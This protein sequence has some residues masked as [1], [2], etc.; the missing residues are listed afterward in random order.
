MQPPETTFEPDFVPNAQ[1]VFWD[2]MAEFYDARDLIAVDSPGH[3]RLYAAMYRKPRAL[4]IARL[5]RMDADEMGPGTRDGQ[6]F[7]PTIG[8]LAGLVFKRYGIAPDMAVAQLYRDGD[9]MCA[10]HADSELV[11]GP[12]AG[13]ALVCIMSFGATRKLSMRPTGIEPDHE[14][15]SIDFDLT[16]GSLFTMDG[17]TQR[18]YLHSIP[19]APEGTGPRISLTF[20]FRQ[21]DKAKKLPWLLMRADGH[22]KRTHAVPLFSGRPPELAEAWERW[23]DEHGPFVAVSPKGREHRSLYRF[24]VDVLKEREDE[25]TMSADQFNTGI[26]HLIDTGALPPP[27]AIDLAPFD[28]AWLGSLGDRLVKEM[29]RRTAVQ[30]EDNEAMEQQ[31][32]SLEAELDE[33]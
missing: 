26:Q 19:P 13:R 5:F 6:F 31:C 4:D 32:R 2:L 33:G 28:I 17:E 16:P 29:E 14:V 1:E 20:I 22:R 24:R 23:E 27:E 21:Q 12:H 11:A 18:H 25:E 8:M 30:R 10:Y 15:G 9:D 7:T 3:K